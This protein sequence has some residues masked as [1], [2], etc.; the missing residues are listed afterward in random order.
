MHAHDWLATAT[1]QLEDACIIT[2][3]LDS[4]V[5]LEDELSKDRGWLLAHPEYVLQDADLS[6]LNAK[7][8][9]RSKHI[10]LAYIRRKVEFYGREFIVSPHTLIPRPETET[11]IDILKTL[12]LPV[13]SR[14]LDIGTGSGCIAITTSLELPSSQVSACDIDEDCLEI[15]KQNTQ[16]LGGSVTF[17]KSDLLTQTHEQYDVLLANLPYVPND[18][19]INMAA[20]YEPPRALFGGNDGLDVYRKLFTQLT[21]GEQARYILTESLPAQHKSLVAIAEAAGFTLREADDLI[22]LFESL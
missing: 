14:L 9:K 18:F 2:A 19:R 8:E 17:L 4:L 20:T 7:L 5:L 10:P 21:A 13:N 12:K 6:A 22:Q 1:K 16:R 11:M 15:A 3:R